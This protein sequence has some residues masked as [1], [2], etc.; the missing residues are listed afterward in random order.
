MGILHENDAEKTKL[1]IEN[2]SCTSTEPK[3]KDLVEHHT[4]IGLKALISVEAQRK[5]NQLISQQH[6]LAPLS[7]ESILQ[8]IQR[9]DLK[10][11]LETAITSPPIAYYLSQDYSS[12]NT[13]EN[14]VIP[15][16]FGE[17][18]SGSKDH[19]QKPNNNNDSNQLNR[20]RNNDRTFKASRNYSRSLYHLSNN[21]NVYAGNKQMTSCK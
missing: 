15:V 12:I 4:T 17:L 3:I 18:S 10:Y 21:C 2:P 7:K 5:I 9:A 14:P 6:E 16:E 13:P 1:F 19:Y 11:P 8:A 20:P